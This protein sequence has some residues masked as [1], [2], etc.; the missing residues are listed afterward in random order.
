MALEL[1]NLTTSNRKHPSV[2]FWLTVAL[3]AAI[4]AYPLSFGPACW[5]ALR[6]SLPKQP[7]ARLYKPLIAATFNCPKPVRQTLRKYAEWFAPRPA[8]PLIV[9]IHRDP[10]YLG[11]LEKLRHTD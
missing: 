5:L 1:W 11:I 10:I 6:G 2:A 3:V 9:S 4:V 7:T 8:I